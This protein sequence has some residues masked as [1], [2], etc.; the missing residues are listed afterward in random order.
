MGDNRRRMV[1]CFCDPPLSA[2]GANRLCVVT[3]NT[4]LLGRIAMWIGP[5]TDEG[6]NWGDL[7]R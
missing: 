3:D 2:V 5:L 7:G 1:S 4:L 6:A